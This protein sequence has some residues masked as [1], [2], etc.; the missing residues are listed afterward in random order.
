MKISIITPSFNQAE[1]IERTI[2]SV[3][4]QEWDFDIEFIIMDWWSNDWS[5][6]IIEKYHKLVSTE[7]YKIK[8]KSI[9]FV[10]KSEKDKWQSDAINKWLRISTWDIITY[11]NSDDTYNDWALQLVTDYLW[12]SESSWCYAKC[13]II[14]KEDREIRKWITSYKN[15]IGWKYR[16]SRLLSENFISQ[17][18]VFWKRE[19]MEKVGLFNIDEHL[20]MDY[21]YWLKLWKV[22]DP[23]YIPF[24]TAN[25]RFYHTSKSWSRF[26]VQFKDELRLATKHAEWKYKF[27]LI[28]HT[29]N[30]YKIVFIYKILWLLKI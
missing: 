26:K 21:E 4:S 2:L 16:Y 7:E 8:C 1:Y 19:A 12:K 10:W 22:S 24:Y 13:K 15:I 6:E 14:D 28:L 5:I 25:F 11:L 23:V 3:I 17:M 30:Y 29:F 9:S 18:T 20:C 27:S